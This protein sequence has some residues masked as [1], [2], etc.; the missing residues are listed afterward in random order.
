M[1]V[2]DDGA[3]KFLAAAGF[4]DDAHKRIGH[5]VDGVS[6]ASHFP[7]P[8]HQE[9]LREGR[10]FTVD[11][12]S[13]P[14]EY[15]KPEFGPTETL[16]VPLRIG[17]QLIGI[18]VLNPHRSAHSYTRAEIELAET[19]GQLA[20]IVVERSRLRREREEAVTRVRALEESQRRMDEFL[21]I[22]SHELRTPLTSI[23]ASLQLTT[24]YIAA[25]LGSLRGEASEAEHDLTTL[26]ERL[27]RAHQ[28]LRRSDR[29]LNRLTDLVTDMLDVSQFQRGELGLRQKR[30]DLVTIV[31]TAVDEQRLV[32]SRRAIDFD[33]QSTSAAVVTADPQRIGQV[34]GHFLVNA[35]KYSRPDQPVRVVVTTTDGWVHVAVSDAGPGLS[36]AQQRQIWERFHRVSGVAVQSGS[37][38]GLGLGLFLSRTIV[39]H[40]GGEVGVDSAPG[41]GSTFWFRLPIATDLRLMPTDR[42]F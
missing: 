16:I 6:L 19:V 36:Q 11:L 14:Y 1:R 28:L 7:N 37:G 22:A 25:I 4:S 13:P 3:T 30:C 26:F 23:K 17:T 29:H 9:W 2:E 42:R 35:L 15:G 38:L 27:E 8:I 34:V 41:V 40:H 5:V 18:L 31:R 24:V 39:Q 20:A 10:S 32:V 12:T 21:G 33:D